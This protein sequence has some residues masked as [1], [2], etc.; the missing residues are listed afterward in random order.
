MPA[1]EPRGPTQ[2]DWSVII[3]ATDAPD[4]PPERRALRATISWPT[5]RIVRV[6]ISMIAATAFVAG[7]TPF[8]IVLKT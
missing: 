1:R 3:S 4:R 5:T 6:M 7:V 2:A 8:R